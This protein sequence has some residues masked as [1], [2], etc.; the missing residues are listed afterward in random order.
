[1]TPIAC[2]LDHIQ[3]VTYEYYYNLQKKWRISQMSAA[4]T[5]ATFCG[6]IK[7]PA[8]ASGILHRLYMLPQIQPCLWPVS[9]QLISEP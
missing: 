5:S 8:P 9:Q 7:H 4:M 3:N 1:M 2:V 6:N